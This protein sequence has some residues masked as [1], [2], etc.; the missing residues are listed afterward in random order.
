MSNTYLENGYMK[1]VSKLIIQLRG[2]LVELFPDLTM[3]ELKE[4]KAL[5]NDEIEERRRLTK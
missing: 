5:I 3:E 2:D 1:A 4:L